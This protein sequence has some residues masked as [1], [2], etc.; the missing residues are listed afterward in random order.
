MH[1]KF[2]FPCKAFAAELMLVSRAVYQVLGLVI[3][4][5]VLK[6]LGETE[7]QNILAEKALAIYIQM[8]HGG[9]LF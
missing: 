6:T 4:N 1:R 8:R 2:Y 9:P 3:N 7:T 5:T